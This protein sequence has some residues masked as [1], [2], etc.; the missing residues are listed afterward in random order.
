MGRVV[1]LLTAVT[2][3]TAGCATS[4]NDSAATTTV[5]AAT[6][7]VLLP[8]TDH[9]T[10]PLPAERVGAPTTSAPVA[11][12]S[13]ESNLSP[14]TGL[15]E[16]LPDGLQIWDADRITSVASGSLTTQLFA[17]RNASGDAVQRGVI[18]TVGYPDTALPAAD[19]STTTIRGNIA[20]DEPATALADFSWRWT[21]NG[22]G[23]TARSRGM[24]KS[25]AVA[26]LDGL[27]WRS[28]QP[29]GFDASS[30][31]LALLSETLRVAGDTS[32]VT[33]YTL[34][35]SADRIPASS[36]VVSI[37]DN[38]V[39]SKQE[40]VFG[41][42]RDASGRTICD[43]CSNNAQEVALTVLGEIVAFA[44]DDH[45][46]NAALLDDV[47]TVPGEVLDDQITASTARQAQ[48]PLIASATVG[49]G[50]IEQRGKGAHTPTSQCILVDDRRRCTILDRSRS[51]GTEQLPGTIAVIDG[52]W[53]IAMVSSADDPSPTLSIQDPNG[54]P[55]PSGI[56]PLD[57]SSVTV[58]GR[59][60]S[61]FA[62]PDSV[63]D[64][65]AGG[66][67]GDPIGHGQYHRP[68]FTGTN[69]AAATT[70]EPRRG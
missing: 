63:G 5:S 49:G 36:I 10:V 53:Y 44:A 59:R 64:A 4:D 45:R 41:G 24:T 3:V 29:D 57:P 23:L 62:V 7:S 46:A 48:L 61:L 40:I 12:K 66:D 43:T 58:A 56:I 35:D 18:V 14:V 47:T 55:D 30:S 69:S 11:D 39:V 60:W 52:H 26:L 9:A 16:P 27:T 1:F 38:H 70:G 25:A 6:S 8:T 32:L 19:A 33:H 34:A 2:V 21:E 17:K 54:R 15:V 13:H 22:Y 20:V 51:I 68:N 65:Y 42:V 50:V 31:P 37:G 67:D 28:F